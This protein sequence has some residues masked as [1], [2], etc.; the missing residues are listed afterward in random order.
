[1]TSK[2][3]F[4]SSDPHRKKYQC[5]GTSEIVLHHGWFERY[6]LPS[7]NVAGSIDLKFAEKDDFTASKT[8]GKSESFTIPRF[9][10]VCLF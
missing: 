5:C 10:G 2:L 7:R 8:S 9:G 4:P 3:K 6:L 1:M